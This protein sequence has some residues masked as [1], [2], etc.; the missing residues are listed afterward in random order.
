MRNPMLFPV[1]VL[2]RLVGG[3]KKKSRSSRSPLHL[4]A[5]L[6][7][8]LKVGARRPT[9]DWTSA[10]LCCFAVPTRLRSEHQL[11]VIGT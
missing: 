10:L 8:S 7:P 2:K 4:Y 6:H 1:H 9:A 3:M 5:C 11:V